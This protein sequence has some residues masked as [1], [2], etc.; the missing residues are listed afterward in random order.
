MYRLIRP[1]L[2]ALDAEKAHRVALQSLKF[3]A[4]LRLLPTPTS[5]T[6]P[7]KRSIMGLHFPNLIGLAAGLDKN[8][9]YIDALAALGFGSIEIGTVTPR[10]QS[11]NPMPRLFRLTTAGAIINRMGFNNKGID[12]VKARLA[13]RRY[14]GILGVNIGKNKA[15]PNERAIDDYLLGFRELAPYAS[16][17][18]MNISSPNTLG[19]RDLQHANSLAPILSALKEAQYQLK[20]HTGHY[21][22]LVVK[23]APDLQN[24]DIASLAT[25]F[26]DADIDG[27]IACNTTIRRDGIT[28]VAHANEAGGLSGLPVRGHSTAVIQQLHQ[29]LATR[30]PIIG[31]GGIADESSAREKLAA[32]ASLLQIYTGL[33]YEGPSLVRRLTQ[34]S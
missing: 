21:S 23:I 16:Y 7:A 2:F 13:Q 27:V 26:L 10:P 14:R 6:A 19:L 29:H 9:D 11:G 4:K 5:S 31:C 28:N 25:V 20:Q 30:I 22:P 32:G 3:A 12:Y 8:G 15:T 17:V 33:I 1:C 34:L 18:T 24:T